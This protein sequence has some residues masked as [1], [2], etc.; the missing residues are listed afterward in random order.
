MDA[1]TEE[2]SKTMTHLASLTAASI[3]ATNAFEAAA[4]E[5]R[6]TGINTDNANVLRA[7]ADYATAN[8][9]AAVDAIR[10]PLPVE[11]YDLVSL[12]AAIE[13]A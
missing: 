9:M 2:Q 3:K 5:V 7:V 10:L 12:L 8:L 13:A 11:S 1:A 4:V 6:R